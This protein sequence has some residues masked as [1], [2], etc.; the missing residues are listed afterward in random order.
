MAISVRRPR[1]FTVEEYLTLER[2]SDAKSEWLDGRIYLMS[3]GSPRHNR[4]QANLVGELHGRLKGTSCQEFTSDSK[5]RVLMPGQAGKGLFTYPDATVVCGEPLY[6]DTE[7]DVLI[8]PK[9]LFE[10]LSPSTE[11]YDRGLKRVRYQAIPS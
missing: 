5:V 3:G 10:V 6:H 11:D 8:N 1:R 4:I 9:V 7:K 2:M